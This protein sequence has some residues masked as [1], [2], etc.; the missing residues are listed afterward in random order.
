MWVAVALSRGLGLWALVLV[1]PAVASR[2]WLAVS[3]VIAGLVSGAASAARQQATL[4][5]EVPEGRVTVAGRLADDARPFGFELR[6]PLDISH[7]L[8]PDGWSPWVAPRV[9]VV[10]GE[11]PEAV[12]GERVMV[13]G[14]MRAEPGF[15]RGDPMAGRIERATVERVAGA[16][17]P[18]FQAGNAVRRR[19]ADVLDDGGRGGALLAGF[20]VGD[21]DR[22]PRSDVD[23]LRLAGLSHFVAVSGSNV[24]LFLAA[25]FLA[26]GPL[27]WDPGRRAVMGLVGLALFLVVTRWEPS[28]V[29]AALMAALVLVGRVAGVGLTPWAALGTAVTASLLVG[30]HLSGD[31]GFQLSV[32]ATAGVL[33]GSGWVRPRRWGVMGQGLAITLGAQAAVAPLLLWH[34]GTV[35]LLSPLTNLVAAPVVTLATGLGGVAVA[36]GWSMAV[37]AATWLAGVVL[38]ISEVAAGWPQLNVMGVAGAVGVGVLA[39]PRSLRPFVALGVGLAVVVWLLPAAAVRVPTLVFIDV[40]QGDATLL[41]DPGGAT[42]LVDGGVDPDLL[43]SKLRARGVTHVD[44]MVATHG[45]LDH[46]GGLPAVLDSYPVGRLWHPNHVEGS[47]DYLALLAQAD[48]AGVARDQPVV[49]WTVQ[50]GAFRIEVLGPARRYADINDESIVLSV[51]SGGQSALLTGDIEATAQGELGVVR[52]DI[53][54]V[55]HHG[56]A[57]TDLA[58][59]AASRAPVAVISVGANRFGHP[60]PD[61][62]AVLGSDHVEVLRTDERGDVVIPLAGRVAESSR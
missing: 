43:L 41:L 21:V 6:A 10:L 52:A 27:A 11:V 61:V 17:D 45:D 28:V 37:A 3:L 44:L 36:S 34:F 53:L 22:L 42:V 51:T 31:V 14:R 13:V 20:L 12:A 19:V 57:T 50:L 35:P 30:G 18:L 2:R 25:W 23:N 1:V 40:G 38:T 9:A 55:P 33:V 29:R 47:E 39:R 8:T 54:K 24:A 48:V 32:A 26:A 15:L 56:A 62:L 7:L 49:G 60:H 58:W 46:I 5:A 59:L 4:E 16:G